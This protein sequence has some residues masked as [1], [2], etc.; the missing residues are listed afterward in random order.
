VFQNSNGGWTVKTVLYAM[1][2]ET[3][4]I[5]DNYQCEIKLGYQLEGKKNATPYNIE[6]YLFFPNSLGI[7]RYTYRK[8]DFYNDMQAYIRL[9]TPTVLL[10]DMVTGDKNPLEKLRASVERLIS[11]INQ[12]SIV[13][14]EYQV[15]MLCCIFKSA[16]RNHVSF[17][18]TKAN[19]GDI[20]DLLRKYLTNIREITQSFR[21]LRSIINVP[22]INA[23]IF[24]IYE[25][26][27]EYLSLLIESYTYELLDV[28]QSM[29]LM[30]T[31]TYT[32]LLLTLVTHEVDYRREN[33]YPSIPHED[34]DNEGFIFRTSVL[35]KYAGNVL[36]LNTR[37][38]HEGE[39]LEQ[40]VFA[41]AAGIAMMFAVTAS[42][43][44][45]SAYT[46]VSLPFF[47]VLIVSY[48]F[49]DRIKEFIRK[50]LGSKL[51]YLLFDHKL[52]IHYNTGENIGW[53]KES[54]S[55]L[56][57][58]KIPQRI[59][60]LRDR[61]HF[62]EIENGRMGEKTLLYRKRIKLFRRKL[63][64]IH[65]DYRVES[66]NDIMRL[67]VFKFLSKMDNPQKP[68]YISNGQTY[69]KISGQRVYHVNMIIKY[70]LRDST[71]YKRFRIVL[72][73]NGIKRIEEV[74]FD[75]E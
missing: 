67:N 29:E 10:H 25:F 30:K 11:R 57:A 42:F 70:S 37:V 51:R 65:R 23:K 5:H 68:I 49:K 24:S 8:D 75:E 19:V 47:I 9:K 71:L 54:F 32:P 44:A 28:L 66:V 39:L 45:Q 3:I 58:R 48:M 12:T 52:N 55:F 13:H 43:F 31:D 72:N 16:I 62:T 18:S 38:R 73:R 74:V 21:A 64:H 69:R 36:F 53:C 20:E 15:K 41:F 63:Q 26:G 4:H 61:E 46:S 22:S 59:M 6:T 40:L 56:T 35:K 27:D 14:Y 17:I 60:D 50:Y 33:N 1:I 34:S 7:N 2:E